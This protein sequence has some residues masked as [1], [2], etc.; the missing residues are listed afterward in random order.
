MAETATTEVLAFGRRQ[1]PCPR[2]LFWLP[3]TIPSLTSYPPLNPRYLPLHQSDC[4][5]TPIEIGC[6]Q[7]C[8]CCDLLRVRPSLKCSVTRVP[9]SI[10]LFQS[11]LCG[12][13]PLTSLVQRIKSASPYVPLTPPSEVRILSLHPLLSSYELPMCLST[14]SILMERL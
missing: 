10:Y 3:R 5:A 9:P 7:S 13:S 4:G 12:L 6:C 14:C 1:M 11:C 2:L 8:P